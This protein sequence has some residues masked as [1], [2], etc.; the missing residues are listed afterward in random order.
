VTALGT[1]K[2]KEGTEATWRPS[3]SPHTLGSRMCPRDWL[4]SLHRLKMHLEIKK[5][6]IQI[7]VYPKHNPK[8][9]CNIHIQLVILIN[10]S[11]LFQEF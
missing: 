4:S 6:R 3:S 10:L 11:V 8:R 1:S 5:Q 2:Q 7:T 9:K